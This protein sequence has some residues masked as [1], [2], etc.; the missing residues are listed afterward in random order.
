MCFQSAVPEQ[1]SLTPLSA[2]I[3]RGSIRRCTRIFTFVREQRIRRHRAVKSKPNRAIGN[4]PHTSEP[5]RQPNTASFKTIWHKN[6]ENLTFAR[7]Y[8]LFKR[9]FRN[10]SACESDIIFTYSVMTACFF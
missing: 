7:I 3:R 1:I 9:L 5:S 2:E 4:L 10:N 8:L 6:G